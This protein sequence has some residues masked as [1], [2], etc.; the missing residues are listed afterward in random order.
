MAD[1]G[2]VTVSNDP[3]PS[4]DAP[5]AGFVPGWVIVALCLLVTSLAILDLY[6]L[7]AFWPTSIQGQNGSGTL[8]SSQQIY[9]FSWALR[10]PTELLFFLIVA[11]AGILGALIHTARSLVWYVGNRDLRWSW[12]A[13]NLMLPVVGALAATVFYLV[14]RAGLFSPST[15]AQASPFGFAAVAVLV[16]LFS[17]Q[18]LEKLKQVSSNFFAEGPTGSDHVAPKDS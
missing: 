16:G 2:G 9:Y 4:S 17:E 8:A 6:S 14:L 10:V 11:I 5:G 12:L 13:F 15:A 3:R 7:W 1:D 18:A